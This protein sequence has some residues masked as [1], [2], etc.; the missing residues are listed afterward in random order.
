[1]KSTTLHIKQFAQIVDTRVEFGDL[2]IFVG[3]QATGKSLVLQFLKFAIDRP[4][5]TQKMKSSGF[6]TS[7]S[8]AQHQFASAFLGE[9]Y[10]RC[11]RRS[12]E[13]V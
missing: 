6:S 10:E 13:H 11:F 8:P 3:P 9:G 5:I 2:T 12:E 1:M 7:K 4:A